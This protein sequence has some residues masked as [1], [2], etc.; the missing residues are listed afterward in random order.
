MSNANFR[1]LL[2]VILGA[3][4]TA[5]GISIAQ[6]VV[7]TANERAAAQRVQDQ[8]YGIDDRNQIND[9]VR[10]WSDVTVVDPSIPDGVTPFSM[11]PDLHGTFPPVPSWP[12]LPGGSYPVRPYF[13]PEPKPVPEWVPG[14][15]AM[16]W[17]E[18]YKITI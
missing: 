4:F 7:M 11:L 2:G 1:F 18:P 6:I 15:P 17:Q 9:L 16:P 14:G 13:V 5:V 3:F 12:S 10:Q 8:T